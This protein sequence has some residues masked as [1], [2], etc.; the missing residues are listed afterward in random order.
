[1]PVSPI[2]VRIKA[3]RAAAGTSLALGAGMRRITVVVL[4]AGVTGWVTPSA[5]Q[6]ALHVSAAPNAL[7]GSRASHLPRANAP[8]VDQ[9]ALRVTAAATPS[10]VSLSTGYVSR[11]PARASWTSS[12]TALAGAFT[13]SLLIDAAQTRALARQ[14]WNGFR[15]ANPLLGEHPS[16]GRVNTYTAVA[17]LTVLGVAAVLPPRVRPWLLGAA[18]AVQAVTIRGSVQQGLPIRFPF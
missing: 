16:V 12:H 6:K 13:I 18:L 3:T 5:A 14:G 11:L 8:V 17:G 10:R 4:V 9:R 2:T 15:E 7:L 1:M